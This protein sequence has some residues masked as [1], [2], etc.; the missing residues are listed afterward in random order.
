MANHA[1]ALKTTVEKLA[2][3]L[4]SVPDVTESRQVESSPGVRDS[5]GHP[6]Q[7]EKR[8]EG[9]AYRRDCPVTCRLWSEPRSGRP[10]VSACRGGT[11]RTEWQTGDRSK[12]N[13]PNPLPS[14]NLPRRRF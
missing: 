9:R 6:C 12:S 13:P 3:L 1:P 5:D 8:V 11:E 2:T 7:V 10:R 14:A 4:T